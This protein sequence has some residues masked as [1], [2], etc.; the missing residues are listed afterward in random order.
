MNA[1]LV[2]AKKRELA[3]VSKRIKGHKSDLTRRDMLLRELYGVVP[4]GELAELAMVSPGR[5]SQITEQEEN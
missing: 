3:A 1:R 4:R 2:T 5:V